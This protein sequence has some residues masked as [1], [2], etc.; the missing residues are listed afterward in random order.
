MG[1]EASS[2]SASEPARACPCASE[3]GARCCR[4]SD[5]CNCQ[6]DRDDAAYEE[7]P[8]PAAA[9]RDVFE[10]LKLAQ[11]VVESGG[12]DEALRQTLAKKL[13]AARAAC[14]HAYK[15]PAKHL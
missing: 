5:G 6:N 9:R 3:S 7:C 12:G 8:I 11:K 2:A 1:Q 15:C 10:A 13:E 4:C 14:P